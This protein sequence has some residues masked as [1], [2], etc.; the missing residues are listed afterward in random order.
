MPSRGPGWL[1]V[2]TDPQ[3]L[4]PAVGDNVGG[5]AIDAGYAYVLGHT[6][7]VDETQQML[8]GAFVE[9]L[10][11]G[12]TLAEAVGLSRRTL[13][14]TLRVIGD[15]LGRMPVPL[16]GF[17]A[18]T[19]EEGQLVAVYDASA[20]EADLTGVLDDGE[21]AML[22]TATDQYGSESEGV[23]FVFESDGGAASS[24]LT[25][26]QRVQAA[27]VA[28]GFIEVTWTVVSVPGQVHPAEWE[29]GRRLVSGATTIEGTTSSPVGAQRV[30]T[31]VG[32]Y[33]HEETVQLVVRAS[34][35]QAGGRRGRWV[36]ANVVVAD[37]QPPQ[38]AGILDATP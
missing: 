21:W 23:A 27:A 34:D 20:R 6:D 15:P 28:A 8:V 9:A 12:R 35:G 14:S 25:A 1:M 3:A 33:A 17:N 31:T 13:N 36:E 11:E 38:P 10:R 37:A 29:I 24:A 2:V 5:A 19:Q 22:L 18:Y 7:A 16:A 26:V 30:T 32:A 4:P